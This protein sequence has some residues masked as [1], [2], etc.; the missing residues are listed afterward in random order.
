[1]SPKTFKVAQSDHTV[2]K[3]IFRNFGKPRIKIFCF[4]FFLS[5]VS[6][7]LQLYCLPKLFLHFQHWRHTFQSGV[8]LSRRSYGNLKKYQCDQ[9]GL[10][11][12]CFGDIF[13]HKISPNIDQR[14]V[15]LKTSFYIINCF[16]SFLGIFFGENWVIF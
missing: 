7:S 13:S 1:M 12:K 6:S 8:R 5:K 3:I 14:F 2:A 4:Q 10:F 11:L 16:D 9:I 15:I